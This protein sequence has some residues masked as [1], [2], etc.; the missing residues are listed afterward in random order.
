M[1]RGV[2]E[3]AS[4]LKIWIDILTPKQLLFLHPLALLLED[5]GHSLYLT[6]RDYREV[7][8]LSRLKG[9]H[10]I[11]YGRH[12]GGSL[13][14]KLRQSARRVTRLAREVDMRGIDLAVSF[15]SVEAA[16]VAFGLSIPHIC[17]SDSPHAEAVSRLTVPLSSLLFTPWVVPR[18]AWTR[19]GIPVGSVIQYKALDPYVWT[20]NFNP[21]ASFAQK[22]GLSSGEPLVTVRPP[23]E[24]AAYLLNSEN[25]SATVQI[26]DRLLKSDLSLQI[27]VLPRYGSQLRSLRR[28][29]GKRVRVLAHSV[30]GANLLASSSFFI[31]CGG[32]MTAEAVLLGTPAVSCFPSRPTHVE[33]FLIRQGLIRHTL[34]PAS[35]EKEV[36]RYLY[37]KGLVGKFKERAARLRGMMEDPLPVIADNVENFSD[38]T[39]VRRRAASEP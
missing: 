5:R 36:R 2:W 33:R 35:V 13:A 31:G 37:D 23:E 8:E 30:D 7:N 21:D 10:L 16:R 14:H 11:S 15:S 4:W 17:I 25:V 26:I 1:G 34:D 28:S 3:G 29:F 39:S 18:K 27:A 24:Q 38:A 22:L 6:T 12:G 19:Y 9:V 32:T 20:R